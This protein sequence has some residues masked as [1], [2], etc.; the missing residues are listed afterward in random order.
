WN[1]LNLSASRRGVFL[2]GGFSPPSI[3]GD[4]SEKQWRFALFSF[5]QN[6]FLRLL[7]FQGKGA[8][9]S[10]WLALNEREC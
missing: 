8:I 7:T 3:S 2:W 4:Q 9:L 1:D 6:N 5:P 10:P